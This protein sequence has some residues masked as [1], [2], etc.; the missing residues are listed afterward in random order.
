MSSPAQLAANR[1]N[2][3]L[4]TGPKTPEGK[5]RVAMN[6]LIHGLASAKMFL[7]G[8]EPEEFVE[9][10]KSLGLSYKCVHSGDAALVDE[11]ALAW[12]K[13]RRIT[14][15]QTEIMTACLTGQQMPEPLAKMFGPSPEDALKTLHRYE[16][17]A[18]GVLNRAL[19]QLRI[20]Q[21]QRDDASR[22]GARLAG[23]A[24]LA[25][26]E[27]FIRSDRPVPN[28]ANPISTPATPA[29]GPQTTSIHP[30]G[31]TPLPGSGPKDPWRR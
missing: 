21:K 22:A 19:N 25:S 26:F 16:V 14:E 28:R 30:E 13:L 12:W 10:Q 9:L 20:H 29:N 5:A 3:E 4:S 17:S 6:P 8:E 23:K 24:S 1:A 31:P 18:H 2:A 7:P 11:A 15:W 27:E